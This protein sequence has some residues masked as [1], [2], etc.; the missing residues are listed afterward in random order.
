MLGTRPPALCPPVIW[1]GTA[2]SGL[3]TLCCGVILTGQ[4][5]GG[6]AVTGTCSMVPGT[7]GL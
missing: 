1:V 3:R 6:R 5:H 7:H 2:S 4:G